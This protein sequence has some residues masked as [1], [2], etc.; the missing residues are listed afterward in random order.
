MVSVNDPRIIAGNRVHTHARLL[1][2]QSKCRRMYGPAWKIKLV[3]GTVI[4]MKTDRIKGRRVTSVRA[5]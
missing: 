2:T 5:K 4:G 3:V 1:T